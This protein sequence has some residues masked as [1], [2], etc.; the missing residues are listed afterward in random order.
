MEMKL[1]HLLTKNLLISEMCVFLKDL[2][3][4]SAKCKMQEKEEE[5][6]YINMN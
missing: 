2:D 1:I 4:E 3:A 6:F 5:Y